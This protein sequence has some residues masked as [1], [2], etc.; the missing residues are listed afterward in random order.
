ML[1]QR[2]E[3]MK[4]RKAHSVCGNCGQM[5]HRKPDDIDN[6]AEMPLEGLRENED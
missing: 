6:Y 1:D 4:K 3:L 5:T 2:D